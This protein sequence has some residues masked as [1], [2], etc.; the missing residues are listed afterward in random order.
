LWNLALASSPELREAAAEL[1]IARGQRIQAAKYPNP[2]VRAE[3]EAL[4][5][6]VNPAGTVRV[7]LSQEIVT[8]GK[9][10]LDMAVA[11]REFDAATLGLIARKFEALTRVRR[12]YYDFVAWSEAVRINQE[13]VRGLE[14]AAQI[15][16]QRVEKA[17]TRPRTDLLRIEGLVEEARIHL[18]RSRAMLEASW[19]QLADAIG[20]P[21]LPL[22]CEVPVPD[23]PAP[24]WAID[25]VRSR[26]QGQ[27]AEL[28]RAGAEVE[29]TRLAAERARAEAV[30]NVKVGGGYFRSFAEME[31]GGLISV[32]TSVPL[33]DRKQGLVHQAEARWAQAQAAQ[34]S[35]ALRLDRETAAAFARYQSAQ[36]EVRKLQEEVLPRSEESLRGVQKLYQAGSN[37]ATF[38]DV[39]QTQDTVNDARR[40]LV[41]ARQELWAAVAELAGLMQLDL[42]EDMELCQPVGRP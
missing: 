2:Q 1:E 28:R 22:P 12:G 33:W 3:Q 13:I 36:Q 15:T 26:V 11:D 8:G 42:G 39:L 32:E 17:Q 21:D 24:H 38:A 4:G 20:L 40:R 6:S 37:E 27:N 14:Q 10:R 19:W 16:R 5:T 23:G 31:A 34:R 9:R 35:L 18:N 30:P 7:E 41:S 29:R 25:A